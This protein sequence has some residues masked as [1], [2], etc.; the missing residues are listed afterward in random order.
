MLPGRPVPADTRVSPAAGRWS[1]RW[2]AVVLGTLGTFATVG[3]TATPMGASAAD[4]RAC[5]TI[6]TDAERLRCYDAAFGR[7][8]DAPP[9]ASDAA[10]LTP[11]PRPGLAASDSVLSRIWELEPDH[12]RG[13]FLLLPHRANYF[14][15]VR[16]SD[17][18]NQQPTSPAAGRT[19]AVPSDLS[20]TEA[21]FQVSFKVKAFENTAGDNG[22]F[23]LAYTQQSNWQVYSDEI[24]A[25]FRESDYEPELIY[26]WRT[27]RAL[28]GWRW[29]LT[30]LGLVHQS[31]GRSEP[32]SRSWNRVYA[33]LGFERGNFTLLV[34]PWYA[35]DL[36]DN[37]DIRRFMGSGDIRLNYATGGHVLSALGRY[38]L[39]GGRGAAQLDWAF[40]ITGALKGYLQL[41]SGYGESLIDYNH[42]QTA[43]GVGLLL[44]P[45]Q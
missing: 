16:Y 1:V 19:V 6:S 9:P 35:F 33:Q 21:K 17:R 25:P 22:D 8:T 24:S 29:R 30:N 5:A 23:W 32:L 7:R 26:T 39:S 31:N 2:R 44:L 42:R 40:P 20:R 12:K 4:T 27:D 11:R 45:W 34:R 3:A 18:V 15:P 10:G 14:L 41:F 37:P 38:S 36:S 43:V 13:T 28:L